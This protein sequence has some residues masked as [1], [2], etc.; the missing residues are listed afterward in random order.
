LDKISFEPMY[1]R[2]VSSTQMMQAIVS[3]VPLR[4]PFII[5][6]QGTE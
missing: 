3:S 4:I 5:A 6:K 2:R 1:Y